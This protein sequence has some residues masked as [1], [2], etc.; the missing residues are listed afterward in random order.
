MRIE[1]KIIAATAFM[2]TVMALA[3]SVPYTLHRQV[4]H[5]LK[6]LSTVESGENLG[7]S[8]LDALNAAVASRRAYLSTG[9]AEF[10]AAYFKALATLKPIRAKLA[11][12]TH[13]TDVQSSN[14]TIVAETEAL[15]SDLDRGMHGTTLASAEEPHLGRIRALIAAEIVSHSLEREQLQQRLAGTSLL[16]LEAGSGAI[17]LGIAIS[18]AAL[19]F[20][21][22]ALHRSAA[23]TSSAENRS[24]FLDG[25]GR[26][27]NALQLADDMEEASAILG[28]Q[29]PKMF[30]Q[31]DGAIYLYR[32]SHDYLERSVSWGEG[33]SADVLAPMECWALRSGCSHFANGARDLHCQHATG[34]DVFCVPLVSHG[35][36]MGILGVAGTAL[37]DGGGVQL[38]DW[39]TQ[40]ASQLAL[41]LS[42]VEL[43]ARLRLQ[44][45]V[46]PLTQLYNRRY[47]DKAFRRELAVAH[48]RGTPLSVVMIDLD[49][50][51][52]VNDSYGHE[53]GDA[54]LSS[55][56]HA[57]REAVRQSDTACRYGGEEMVVLM[58]DCSYENA[59]ERAEALRACIAGIRQ[60]SGVD[61]C[62]WPTASLGVA[63]FPLHGKEASGLVA[64]ADVALYRAKQTGRNRVCGYHQE[65]LAHI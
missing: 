64:A 2:L 8:L 32:S 54:L 7:T 42:N 60:Q 10:N 29:L 23:A 17:L 11:T 49:H 3:A 41:A 58:P 21:Q 43:R 31:L 37:A 18:L 46:D 57:L 36:V 51:K 16:A 35:K 19:R 65:A 20:A 59:L 27:V 28:S 48:R 53:R 6:A 63:T 34:D 45:F 62:I 56:G 12:L 33:T 14:L 47:L 15:L 50:F 26:L 5:R 13:G 22:R 38:R 24:H 1:P 39:I 52:R 9:N 25:C 4:M 61:D 30:P 55:V 44:S 40:L